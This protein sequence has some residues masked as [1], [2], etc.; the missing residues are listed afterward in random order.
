MVKARKKIMVILAK[1]LS[2]GQLA[3]DNAG[4]VEPACERLPRRLLLGRLQIDAKPALRRQDLVRA[5]Q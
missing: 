1:F 3:R 2:L 4:T 5:Y